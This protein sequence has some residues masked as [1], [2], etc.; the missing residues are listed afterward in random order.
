MREA[1]V[2]SPDRTLTTLFSTFNSN[3]LVNHRSWEKNIHGISLSSMSKL[4]VEQRSFTL[5]D[6]DGAAAPK[7]SKLQRWKDHMKKWWWLY[8]VGLCCVILLTVLPM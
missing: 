7:P 3:N 6:N 8:L 2:I 5:E 1:K 4:D